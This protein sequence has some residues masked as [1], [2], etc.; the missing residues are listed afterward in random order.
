[1]SDRARAIE[2][3]KVQLVHQPTVKTRHRKP[4][5]ANP[6]APWELRVGRLRV[7]DDVRADPEPTVEILAIGVKDRNEVR[8]GGKA[9][10]L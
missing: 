5:Q 3:I 2:A 1:M 6:I 4:L 9:V 8:I 10:K 7:Y